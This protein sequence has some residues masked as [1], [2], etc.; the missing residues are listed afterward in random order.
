MDE[1]FDS[2]PEDNAESAAPLWVITFSDLVTLFLCF[3]VLLSSFARVDTETF[4]SALGSVRKA[5]NGPAQPAR[6][7]AAHPPAQ[8]VAKLREQEHESGSERERLVVSR[9][10]DYLAARGLSSEVEV[11]AAE[12]GIVLRTRA[13]VLFNSA[14]ATLRA[15]ASPVLEAVR[16]LASHFRGQLAVEGHT[17]TRPI[18]NDEYA[19]N[20]ELSEARSAAVLHYLLRAKLD[21]SHVHVAGY[22]DQRPIAGNETEEGRAKNRRVEFVFEWGRD[23]DPSTAFVL[24][25]DG[26]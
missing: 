8:E 21:P 5:L 1:E 9:L 25:S 14:A 6:A 23:L 2:P 12:R 19:S 17:D 11:T 10:R 18:Q 7:A 24:P 26:R 16:D 13:Q 15:E 4:H 3:F 22:A 20:W